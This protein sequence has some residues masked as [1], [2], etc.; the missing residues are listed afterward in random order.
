M[1]V[2]TG[3]DVLVG[4]DVSEVADEVDAPAL[5]CDCDCVTMRLDDCMADDD[6]VDT[7][8]L[9]PLRICRALSGS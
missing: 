8:V 4:I 7:L 5:D 6:V 1:D 3:S 9:S 2:A